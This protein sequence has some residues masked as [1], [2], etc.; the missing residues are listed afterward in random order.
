MSPSPSAPKIAS[1]RACSPTS[2]SECPIEVAVVSD[3]HPAQPDRVARARTDGRRSRCRCGCPSHAPASSRGRAK[4]SGVVILSS[5]RDRRRPARPGRR[6]P[7]PRRRRWRRAAVRPGCGR[8]DLRR[9]ESPAASGRARGPRGPSVVDTVPS[10]ALER[11]GDRQGRAGALGVAQRVQHARDH[12]LGTN[13]RAASW[14]S[15]RPGPAAPGP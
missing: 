1:V 2:A 4:S 12:R 9:S 6:P 3:L 11:V 10:R 14:I 7:R 8:E 13:G 5:P 15:T